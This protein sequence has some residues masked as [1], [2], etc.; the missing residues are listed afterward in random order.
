M[1]V[2]VG[3]VLQNFEM[4]IYDPVK[5]DFGKISLEG[6][7]AK[8]QWLILFFYPADFT[9]VCPT[10]LNDLAEKYNE[11]KAAGCE[12]VS[13]ST[14]TKFSHLAWQQSEKLLQNVKYPMGADPTGVVSKMFGVYDES[15]GLA[16]RGAFIIS[17]E[18][19]LAA[20]EVN[21][22][23]VGRNASELLRKVKANTYL[24]AHPDEVCPANWTEGKKTLKPSAKMVG[25]VYESIAK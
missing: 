1:S 9:F 17:P 2:R 24:A 6:V 22:Y 15:T 23:N 16:L 19:K 25:K 14:D 3:E 10:E 7:K 21:F 13:V 18:G 11:L 8:R 5:G 4:D 20:S 12:V